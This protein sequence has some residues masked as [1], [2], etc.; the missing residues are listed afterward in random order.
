MDTFQLKH[1]NSTKTTYCIVCAYDM[2]RAIRLVHLRS[3]TESSLASGHGF[4]IP[5]CKQSSGLEVIKPE[6]SQTQNKASENELR[7]YNL[8]ALA[9]LCLIFPCVFVTFQYSVSGQMWYLIVSIP[10]LCLLYFYS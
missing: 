6:Y 9:L 10:D 7:F 8:E 2:R 3:G 1:A 4:K 5:N